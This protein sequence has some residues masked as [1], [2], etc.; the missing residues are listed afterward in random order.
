LKLRLG[1]KDIK[2]VTSLGETGLHYH[3]GWRLAWGVLAIVCATYGVERP[4]GL[5]GAIATFPDFLTL[6]DHTWQL[7]SEPVVWTL[8]TLHENCV[9]VLVVESSKVINTSA[10]TLLNSNPIT[11]EAAPLGGIS[12]WVSLELI[13]IGSTLEVKSIAIECSCV[14]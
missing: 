12:P 3:T 9:V 11:S 8:V 13:S 2:N 10:A 6:A 7:L 1:C 14:V 4:L 5:V